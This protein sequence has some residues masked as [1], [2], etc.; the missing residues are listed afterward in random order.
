MTSSTEPGGSIAGTGRALDALT[1]SFL[2]V[3][4]PPLGKPGWT[5]RHPTLWE[6][7]A[8]WLPTQAHLLT[9]VL[10]GLTDSALLTRV[11][12]QDSGDERD[13]TLLRVPPALYRAVAERLAAIRRKQLPGARSG[14]AAS[15]LSFLSRRSSDAFLRTY[16]E[17]D[18]ALPG[19]LTGFGSYVRWMPETQVL[20]RFHQ[21]SLLSEEVRRKTVDR[22]AVLAVRTPDDGW[23]KGPD[24]EVLLTASDRAMLMDRVRTDLVPQLDDV[25]D[26]ERE[27]DDD[28]I[29]NALFWYERA[30]REAGDHE[31]AD[32]FESARDG[33][34]QLPVRESKDYDEQDRSPL[35]RP[36]LAPEPD[37]GRS[38]FD[39]IDAG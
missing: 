30:F 10:A 27:A 17:V 37:T 23:L 39:D 18:P 12:C 3:T 25:G 33:Y 24:W 1:G 11:D 5:F 7:F 9:V 6:G 32:A 2:Q 26:G 28:P 20:A 19:S 13:G 14:Q 22:M 8:S 29:D 15:L 35:T 34:Q 21:A 16:L 38:I 4:G 36:G 31:T